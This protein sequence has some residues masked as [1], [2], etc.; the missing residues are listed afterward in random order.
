MYTVGSS[1]MYQWLRNV[2]EREFIEKINK[3]S[4]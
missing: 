2:F 4:R 3:I 1:C